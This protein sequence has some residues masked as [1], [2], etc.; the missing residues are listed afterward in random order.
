MPDIA[1]LAQDKPNSAILDAVRG[2]ASTDYARRIPSADVAGVAATIENLT[3]ASNLSL[4][5]I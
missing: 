2:I 1:I 5:H 4:I 3:N